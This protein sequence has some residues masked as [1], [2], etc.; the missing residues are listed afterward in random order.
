MIGVKG[1]DKYYYKNRPNEIHV[2]KN[3]DL[4][5]P[6]KGMVAVFGRSGC[7]KTTLLN[8]IGGL[9]KCRG[10]IEIAGEDLAKD[11]DGIRNKYI[12]YVFQN[13]C[14]NMTRTVFENVADALRL[15]G[16]FDEDDITSRVIAALRSVGMQNYAR[17]M[18]D[19]LSGGQ[20][21]RVAIARAIVKDP[22]VVLADEPT[23][24]LDESNTV[25][26]MDLLKRISKD[27]LVVL[28][29]HEANLVDHYCDKV[30]QLSDGEIV[31]TRE[32]SDANG[33][34]RKDRNTVYLG[35]F[36]KTVSGGELVN[37]DYYGDK[38]YE[39]IKL[40]VVNK[41][42][43]I[44]LR[45]DSDNV[46]LV[47][48]GET[49]FKEGVH[50]KSKNNFD[51]GEDAVEVLPPLK[52]PKRKP[53]GRLFNLLS[54]IKSG[55]EVNFAS[56]KKGKKF[57]FVVM[58]FFAIVTTFTTAIFATQVK[59]ALGI[60]KEYD[61]NVFYVYVGDQDTADKLYAA[62][63]DK[64]SGIDYVIPTTID[65]YYDTQTTFSNAGTKDYYVS[66]ASFETF[67]GNGSTKAKAKALELDMTLANGLHVVAGKKTAKKGEALI[68]TAVADNMIEN[69]S[70]PYLKSYADFIGLSVSDRYY[71]YDYE[72][73]SVKKN[74][75]RIVGVVRSNETAIYV[76]EE[77]M[78]E[79]AFY[80]LDLYVGKYSDF[81]DI[82]GLPPIRDGQTVF[83]KLNEYNF[84]TDYQVES[85]ESVLINGKEFEV[86]GV[87]NYNE[88][89]KSLIAS[90]NEKLNSLRIYYD[91]YYD[92]IFLLCDGDADSLICYFGATDPRV[93]MHG[94]IENY[95]LADEPSQVKAGSYYSRYMLVHSD[96]VKATENYLSGIVSD[97]S[98]T[99]LITPEYFRK[100][101]ESESAATLL[102]SLIP[103]I[104]LFAILCLTMFL[105]MRSALMSR[106]K[107]I[108]IYRAIGVKK[109]NIIFRF[110]IESV[111]LATLTILLG[112]IISD[113]M[114]F[115]MLGSSAFMSQILYYP[116]WLA[117]LLFAVMFGVCTLCG[118]LPVAALLKK[119]PSEI[120]SK[121]DV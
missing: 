106:V 116:V 112:Y 88:E 67:N 49:R 1:L 7:G 72:D 51:H 96:N 24:N 57:L 117:V 41:D 40:T 29:T 69:I 8:A 31:S 26:I 62:K 11:T 4:E 38:P 98:P 121:Y 108:G 9:D 32:N 50:Q 63:D 46:H 66:I 91:R 56:G 105:I 109:S 81:A 22:L 3:L 85:G 6:D 5:L 65:I 59:A 25:L 23:G 86:S 36:E 34:D 79:N 78:T 48:D 120:L 77:T 101:S 89:N 44:Y 14:L 110:F 107:E 75:Y 104:V 82:E 93:S 84:G 102:E 2:L 95:L 58:L 114:I 64:N 39:P 37:V 28:V 60:Y 115:Y 16:V 18:P 94:D 100:N 35:E 92:R 21:Q 87:I 99:N 80:S 19:T 20:Q 17:R 33:Y 61:R 43:K 111:V 74:G 90:V 47:D 15:Y 12:G 10:K 30:I 70:M 71:N 54:A 73:T 42:G 119:T 113:A 45:I 118:T 103:L 13:Y 97:T 83:I 53:M 52:N 27:H 55:Y 76:P 68:S